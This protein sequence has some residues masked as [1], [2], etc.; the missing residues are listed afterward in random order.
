MT[1]AYIESQQASLQAELDRIYAALVC[2]AGLD[3]TQAKMRP[4]LVE[5]APC[6]SPS[7]PRL[8]HIVQTFGLTSFEGD[9]LLLCA[10]FELDNRFANLSVDINLNS[11]QP[12]PTFGLPFSPLPSAHTSTL[13]PAVPLPRST[14]LHIDL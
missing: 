4:D 13:T 8:E 2:R 1:P 11:A 3:H 10:G 6:P 12:W 9:V 7:S 14:L 5:A